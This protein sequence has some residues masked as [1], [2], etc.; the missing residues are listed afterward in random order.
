MSDLSGLHAV[1]AVE[2]PHHPSLEEGQR[3]AGGREA[4]GGAAVLGLVQVP[5]HVPPPGE[6]LHSKVR[7][8]GWLIGGR[9]G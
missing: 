5:L 8:G 7:T 4:V 6:G 9:Q 1:V 3:L 2:V